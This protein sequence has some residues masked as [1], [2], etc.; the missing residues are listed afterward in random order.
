MRDDSGKSSLQTLDHAI[1]ILEALSAEG[2][3]TGVVEL[4]RILDMPKSTV[5][6]VLSTLRDH[7]FVEQNGFSGKYRLG[8]KL[9]ELGCSYMAQLELNR[10]VRPY[11][12][13]LTLHSGESSHLAVLD[14]NEVVYLHI[15]ESDRPMRA[16]VRAGS[17]T[18]AHCTAAGK[19][20]LAHE[21]QT[22]I[23]D[24]IKS[25][26]SA[27]TAYTITEPEQFRS[28]L[29]HVREL[30]YAISYGEYL[31]DIAGVGAPVWD[32][33]GHVVAAIAVSGP[34]VGFNID[35]LAALV[36][37]AATKASMA[38]GYPPLRVRAR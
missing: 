32:Q 11:L 35:R 7:R 16:F 21:D 17:R 15:L 31:A 23:E 19:A 14:R 9:W 3:E 33:S 25:G 37:Q 6:R 27:Y 28:E 1:A 12:E 24:V 8:L 30:G 13:W 38:M 10:I 5:H 4:G 18:P 26:L 36:S 2:R 20:L 29:D 22:T 34:A